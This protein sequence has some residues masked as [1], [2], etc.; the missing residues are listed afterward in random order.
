MR[1]NIENSGGGGYFWG[2]RFEMVSHVI[3]NFAMNPLD[4]LV[5]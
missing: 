4:H 3:L 1:Y 5:I 2:S